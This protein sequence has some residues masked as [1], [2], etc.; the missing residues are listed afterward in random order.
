MHDCGEEDGEG[1]GRKALVTGHGG[2]PGRAGSRA[3]EAPPGFGLVWA[4]I[5]NPHMH[6]LGGC[7]HKCKHAAPTHAPACA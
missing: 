5:C 2:T 1:P 7:K 4:G 3:V 6:L